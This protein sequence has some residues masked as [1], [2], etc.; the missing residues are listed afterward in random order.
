MAKSQLDQIKS[1]LKSGR[2][3][4]PL[5]ALGLYGV[6]RLAARIKELRDKGWPITTDN[7]TD[8]NGKKY[9]VYFLEDKGT[10]GLPDFALPEWAQRGDVA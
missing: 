5:E 9:A 10:H 6:F 4:S 8:P 1:H 7:R 3:I 2:T